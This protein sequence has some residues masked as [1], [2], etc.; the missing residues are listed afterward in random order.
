MKLKAVANFL[1]EVGILSKTPRSG[2]HF[3]GSGEQSV[4]EH[5]NRVVYTGYVLASLEKNVDVEKVMKMCLFHDLGE[6]RTSD[7]NYIHQK[8]AHAN[9]A[10]ALA[11]V[12]E[13]VSFGKEILEIVRELK[14][15]KSRESLLA[16]DADILDW[17]LSLREQEDIG[18]SRAKG[19]ITSAIKRLNTDT[20]RKLAMEIVATNSDEWW[21]VNTDEEWWVSRKRSMNKK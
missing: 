7:L 1:Y 6:A 13:T 8:Y 20:A 9:E 15:R 14:E 21:H 18:N 4:A 2:F 17:V 10:E 3:L 5:T 19:W 16:K 12:A 11:D